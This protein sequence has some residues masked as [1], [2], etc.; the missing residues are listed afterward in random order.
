[1]PN[2]LHCLECTVSSVYFLRKSHPSTIRSQHETCAGCH[3]VPPNAPTESEIRLPYERRT[4]PCIARTQPKEQRAAT[5]TPLV[6]PSILEPS[7]PSSSRGGNSSTSSGSSSSS[8]DRPSLIMRWMRPAKVAG[9]SSEKPEVR[10]E[11]S[12]S[13]WTRSLTVLSPLSAAALALSSFMIECLGLISIVFFDAMYEDIDESRSAY[14]RMMR[15]MLAVQPYSPVTR[16]HG[17]SVRC[18]ETT[19]FSVL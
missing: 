13:R 19:T 15:S 5:P 16:Q 4:A 1:M 6:D 14:A 10:S 12:K 7:S 17:A 8:M 11:V 9:S 18:S 3:P 2:A